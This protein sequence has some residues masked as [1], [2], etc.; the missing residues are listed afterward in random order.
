MVRGDFAEPRQAYERVPHGKGLT[1]PASRT[2]VVTSRQ[3]SR[4]VPAM[5]AARGRR[6][7]QPGLRGSSGFPGAGAGPSPYSN[8][9]EL[10]LCGADEFGSTGTY[11]IL[12]WC[13]W[14]AS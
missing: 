10:R 8:P 5:V 1:A 12:T 3:G 9:G 2:P 6:D 14:A 4:D 11:S 7:P 13:Q